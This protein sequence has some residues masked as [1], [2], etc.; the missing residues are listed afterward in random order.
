MDNG[1]EPC[2]TLDDDV[3]NTH[4]A[5]EG[6]KE[7]HKLNRVNI[8]SNNDEGCFLRLDQRNDVIETVFR[9]NRLFCILKGEIR[10]GPKRALYERRTCLLSIFTS[11][12]DTSSRR[13]TS[14]LL[15][16]RLGPVLVKELEQLS[17]CVLVECV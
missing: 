4:L 3:W 9:V 6:R 14:L 12:D 15:L 8:M 7:D 13:E 17:S 5:A 1:A 16:F 10:S 11:C 2:L